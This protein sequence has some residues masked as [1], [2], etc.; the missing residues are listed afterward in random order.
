MDKIHQSMD[1]L[2][3]GNGASRIWSPEVTQVF[4]HVTGGDDAAGN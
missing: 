4:F 3:P 2:H 1:L